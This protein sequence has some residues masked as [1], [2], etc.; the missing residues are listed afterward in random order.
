M[1]TINCAAYSGS[2]EGRCLHP[3]APRRLLGKPRCIALKVRDDLRMPAGCALCSPLPAPS[4]IAAG[5][6]LP[7]NV[8]TAVARG[9]LTS[10]SPA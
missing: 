8:P 4:S 7:G 1:I 9:P 6:S 5:T 2:T 10:A 3:A